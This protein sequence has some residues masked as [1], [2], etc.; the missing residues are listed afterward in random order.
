M[1]KHACNAMNSSHTISWKIDFMF[2]GGLCFTVDRVNENSTLQHAYDV[3]LCSD[4]ARRLALTKEPA[5]STPTDKLI[6]LMLDPHSPV[7]SSITIM[8]FSMMTI[9]IVLFF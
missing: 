1:E 9:L 7:C 8:T 5:F 3:Q 4:S 2:G 6:F